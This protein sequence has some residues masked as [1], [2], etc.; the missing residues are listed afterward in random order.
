[1]KPETARFIKLDRQPSEKVFAADEG[2]E[3][4]SIWNRGSNEI[5]CNIGKINAAPDIIL[6]GIIK[7]NIKRC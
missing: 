3:F 6:H 1:M 5:V 2:D 4:K 7:G